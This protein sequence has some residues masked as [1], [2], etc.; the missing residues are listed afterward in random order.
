M[1]SAEPF[2]FYS[3]LHLIELTGVIV[4]TLPE[5]LEQLKTVN[6]SCIYHHTH[7]FIQQHQHLSPEPANDFA[8]WVAESLGDKQLGEELASIDIM[9]F[10]SIRG[11]REA[12][13]GV[14][15][16][17]LSSRSRLK[18]LSAPEGGRF[19]FLKSVSFI[20]PTKHKACDLGEFV[21]SL[22]DVSIDSIYYHMFES[23]LRLER[24]TNDFSMWLTE[25]MGQK[26]LA[27]KIAKLDPYTRTGENLRAQI[28]E[29]VETRI[30]EEGRQK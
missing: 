27:V 20:F 18:N 22:K 25:A 7:H 6:G 3:R 12:L 11:I 29:L 19:S 13:I 16:K 21:Q 4:S 26:Q 2:V 10:R 17:G 5:L 30:K 9:S 15:E 8:Y 23:R 1:P 14:I 28:I 24:A